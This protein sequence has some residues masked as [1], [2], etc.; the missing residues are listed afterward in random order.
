MKFL[1]MVLLFL[2]TTLTTQAAECVKNLNGLTVQQFDQAYDSLAG[3]VDREIRRTSK[4]P[5]TDGDGWPNFYEATALID[6]TKI[7]RGV[8]DHVICVARNYGYQAEVRANGQKLYLYV[9]IYYLY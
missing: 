3:K 5:D 2:T 9:R 4:S 7:N 1:A 6:V 8:V